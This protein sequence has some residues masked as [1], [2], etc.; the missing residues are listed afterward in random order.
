[1]KWF[2]NKK[3]EVKEVKKEET[4]LLTIFYN[5]NMGGRNSEMRWFADENF[6]VLSKPYLWFLLR[7][8]EKY[9]MKFKGGSCILLRENIAEMS[10]R[11]EMV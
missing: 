5:K 7:D 2:W 8:S 11:K 4:W 9:L 1:M 3:E 10:L 6:R